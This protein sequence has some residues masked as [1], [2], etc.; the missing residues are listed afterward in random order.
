MSESLKGK[1]MYEY[2]NKYKNYKFFS[3]KDLLGNIAS[4]IDLEE[5]KKDKDS[6]EE[7]NQCKFFKIKENNISTFIDGIIS[8]INK[9]EDLYLFFNFIFPIKK[10]NDFE[11][12]DNIVS[13][14]IISHF[15]FLL[16][17]NSNYKIKMKDEYKELIQKIILLSIMN[18]K[19]VEKNNYKELIANL[20]VCS[21]FDQDDLI[22][23]FI[24]KIINSDI[25]EYI[26]LKKK[27]KLVIIY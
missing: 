27:M 24:Q 6:L 9:L 19:E 11:K 8:Q 2:I 21:A 16:N 4:K 12:K 1:E 25:E 14:L 26:T 5:L 23:F 18:I 22:I 10:N 15:L 13:D 17:K 20:G 3:D 7:F